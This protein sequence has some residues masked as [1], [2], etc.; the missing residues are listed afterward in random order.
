MID[1]SAE[2]TGS[3][4]VNGHGKN[5]ASE[6]VET[7]VNIG[8]EF[9]VRAVVDDVEQVIMDVGLGVLVEVTRKEAREIISGRKRLFSALSEDA[10]KRIT[11]VQAH[12]KSVMNSLSKLRVAAPAVAV[13]EESRR[14]DD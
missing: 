9:Y 6:P 12:L 10:T 3:A 13:A 14:D 5:K 4:D 2:L 11:H 1:A 8:Q 7:R